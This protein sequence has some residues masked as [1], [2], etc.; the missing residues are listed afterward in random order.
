MGNAASN[1]D[2]QYQEAM[3]AQRFSNMASVSQFW[4]SQS[5][6]SIYEGQVKCQIL[7]DYEEYKR[8]DKMKLTRDIWVTIIPHLSKKLW[9][10]Q[11]SERKE[12]TA[13]RIIQMLG[14]KPDN[15]KRNNLIVTFRVISNGVKIARSDTERRMRINSHNTFLSKGDTN[16]E[17]Y[18]EDFPFTNKGFTFDWCS[19][20]QDNV[21]VAEFIVEKGNE[22]EI[23]NVKTLAE[24]VK[25][26]HAEK[27]CP[28]CLC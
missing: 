1:L 27:N 20:S 21:G 18:V 4:R 17:G 12:I 13:V 2:S 25:D 22:I 8:V 3:R 14:L 28:T 15:L 7:T 24:Y 5:D 26:F 11:G 10:V 16:L 19:E 23:L 6:I 9:E